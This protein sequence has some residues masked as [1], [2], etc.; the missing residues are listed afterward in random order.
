MGRRRPAEQSSRG[1][2]AMVRAVHIAVVIPFEKS[3]LCV[4]RKVYSNTYVPGPIRSKK[5]FVLASRML[6]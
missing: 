1:E 2:Q 5:K 6:W 3:P 4:T